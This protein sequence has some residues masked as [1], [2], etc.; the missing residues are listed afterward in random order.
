MVRCKHKDAMVQTRKMG[1]CIIIFQQ[2]YNWSLQT[3]WLK[4]TQ[5]CDLIFRRLKF[6]K[7]SHQTRMKVSAQ[8]YSFLLATAR[9]DLFSCLLETVAPSSI[10]RGRSGWKVFPYCTCFLS[11]F[12]L[13]QLILKHSCL[14]WAHHN[15]PG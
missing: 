8:L 2:S 15:N 5:F 1:H 11:G 6:Q 3:H 7:I 12:P 4:T 14:H 9:D 10:G 13:P